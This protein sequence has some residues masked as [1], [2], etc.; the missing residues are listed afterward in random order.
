[1]EI[2]DPTCRTSQR[3][4]ERLHVCF[5]SSVFLC[6]ERECMNEPTTPTA[7]TSMIAVFSTAAMTI[8]AATSEPA[9]MIEK[10]QEQEQERERERE[11]EREGEQG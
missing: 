6:K 4:L 2:R 1:M 11:R 10:E 9:S 5:D 7:T 8:T 3:S